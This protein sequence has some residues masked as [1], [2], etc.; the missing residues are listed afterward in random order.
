MRTSDSL[1]SFDVETAQP[2]HA[3]AVELTAAGRTG[4]RAERFQDVKIGGGR[5]KSFTVG[6]W[7]QLGPGSLKP[8]QLEPAR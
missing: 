8:R 4:S 2:E 5:P 7:A 6:T 3:V 1:T